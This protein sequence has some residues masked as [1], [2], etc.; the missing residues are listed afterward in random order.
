MKQII[1][2]MAVLGMAFCSTACFDAEDENFRTLEP[3]S[4]NEVSGTIDVSL[5]KELVYDKLQIESEL[6]VT[7]EWAYGRPKNLSKDEY[8]MENIEVI[9][10]KADIRYT[11][12]RVGTYLLRLKADNGESIAYKYFTLNVNSGLDEGVLILSNDAEGNGA[13]TFI[14]KRS[15]DE[16]AAGEQE[17]YPDIF[18]SIN[19]DNPLKKGTAMYIS[20]YTSKEVQYTS[21]LVATAD[22]SGTIY[23]LNPKT[24]ELYAVNRLGTEYGASCVE[25][26]GETAISAAYYVLM[27]GNNGHTYR[28]DLFADIIG[29][30]P[31]ASAAGLITHA[32]TLVYRTSATAAPTRKSLLYNKTTLFQPG[33]AKIATRSLDGYDIIN[34]SSASLR[35]VTYV[36]FQS[37]TNPKSYCI[38]STTGA[39]AAFKD[40]TTFTADAICMDEN[41]VMVNSKNSSDV[42]YSYENKIYRW[43]LTSAPPTTAKLT[44]PDGEIIRSMATNFMG[45][46]GDD[47]QETLLYVATFNPNRAGEHKG[48]LYIFQFSDDTLIKKYEGIFDDPAQVMY[49]YRIS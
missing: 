19:P 44:L 28:Y 8:A 35:N 14:K 24:L 48:S 22:E 43:S 21:L 5:G 7:Y 17:V 47:T 32:K 33:N 49:K 2:R 9:S 45:S 26:S 16:I 15:E 23:K 25:F 20:A 6:P 37:Q 11:F 13:L 38:K 10:D 4:F 3:I 30:R 34:L 12:N 39:L 36:L 40:V 18:A 27:R 29:E 46:S 42:Y 1:Y 31:D 41:S